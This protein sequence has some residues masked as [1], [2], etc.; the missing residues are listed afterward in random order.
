MKL[1]EIIMSLKKEIE[2]ISAKLEK[3]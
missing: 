3:A 1:N 2:E